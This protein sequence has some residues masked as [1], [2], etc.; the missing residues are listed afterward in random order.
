MH[1][2]AN[3]SVLGSLFPQGGAKNAACGDG[4]PRLRRWQSPRAAL[5]IA[6]A[7]VFNA[8]SGRIFLRKMTKKRSGP[9]GLL[10]QKLKLTTII[11]LQ[12]N[13]LPKTIEFYDVEYSYFLFALQ[14]YGKYFNVQ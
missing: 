5:G 7:G 13:L 9:H 1:E 6:A 12:T 2:N 11:N 10:L 4:N 3:C 14:R 8:P